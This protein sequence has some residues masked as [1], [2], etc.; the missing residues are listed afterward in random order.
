MVPLVNIKSIH[1]N[2]DLIGVKLGI[3]S[4][5]IKTV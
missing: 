5:N 4:T 2:P 1:Q 3:V